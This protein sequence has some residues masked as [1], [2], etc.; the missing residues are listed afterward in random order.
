LNTGWFMFRSKLCCE[1][2]EGQY[3]VAFVARLAAE[4]I[5]DPKLS[6]IVRSFDSEH[7]KIKFLACSTDYWGC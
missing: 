1:N 4:G 6:L 3:G 2:I 5:P 7:P